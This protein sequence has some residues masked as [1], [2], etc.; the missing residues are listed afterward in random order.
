MMKIGD[1]HLTQ[2]RN[3][4]HVYRA[5]RQWAHRNAPSRRFRVRPTAQGVEIERFK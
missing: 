2:E 4:S 3:P 5:A 1:V